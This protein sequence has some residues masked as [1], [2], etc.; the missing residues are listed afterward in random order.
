MNEFDAE[1][2]ALAEAGEAYLLEQTLLFIKAGKN[3]PPKD[4]ADA[5]RCD[6]VPIPREIL[7]YAAGMLDGSPKRR[8]KPID[9]NFESCK[10]AFS[11][12]WQPYIENSFPEILRREF[13]ELKNDGMNKDEAYENLAIK[14]KLSEIK[15][16]RIIYP[17]RNK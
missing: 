11:N 6:L 12:E 13:T 14:Y 15:I 4:I 3:V 16:S 17:R 5:L 1:D 2:E 8:G 7:D 9:V 10:V